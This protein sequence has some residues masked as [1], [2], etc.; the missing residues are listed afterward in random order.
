MAAF[1]TLALIA[2]GTAIAGAVAKKKLNN[3]TAQPAG[4]LLGGGPLAPA[5][6][7]AGAA[8][9]RGTGSL[10]GGPQPP[11]AQLAGSTSAL[12]AKAAADIAK[13]KAK[14]GDNLLTGTPGASTPKP[15]VQPRS[16]LA[17]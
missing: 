9:P 14:G 1:T 16:L 12:A 5:P 7:G 4:S 2:A 13:R 3:T 8:V 10:L 6:S 17:Y 11:D 15:H